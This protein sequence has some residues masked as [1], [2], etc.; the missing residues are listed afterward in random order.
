[1]KLEIAVLSN[2]VQTFFHV[3][4]LII[5]SLPSIPILDSVFIHHG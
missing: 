5:V 4:L 2:N 3:I 1:M